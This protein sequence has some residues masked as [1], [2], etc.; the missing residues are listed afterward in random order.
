MKTA[1]FDCFSGISGNMILGA[2]LDAGL[3]FNVLKKQLSKLRIKNYKLQITKT[4]KNGIAASYF[5]VH[6]PHASEVHAPHAEHQHRSL[7]NI[8]SLINKS[9]LSS[10][11][12]EKS[13]GIFTRLAKAEAK[14]HGVSVNKIH[15]HEV[16]AV[17]AIVDIV[18]AVC[19]LEIM[20][21]EEIYCSPLPV[22]RG[23]INCA[24]GILPVPAPATAELIK[25]IPVYG[26]RICGEL[27]TPTGSAIIT[28]LAKSFGDCPEMKIRSI[29]YGAGKIDLDQP[30]ALRVLIGETSENMNK[31][32][33]YSVETNIDDMNPQIF[34]DVFESLFSNGALDVYMTSII[35]KKGR[36]GILLTALCK[37]KDINTLSEIIL[38]HTTSLG[39]RIT[40]HS[41]IVADRE[42]KTVKTKYGN[43]RFKIAKLSGKTVN[44][45]PEYEYCKKASK[46]YGVPIKTIMAEIVGAVH[47][48]SVKK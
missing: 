28:T 12:K 27:V 40:K 34:E 30:N 2:L 8:I 13:I 11:V 20:G 24:H 17:D 29:G 3:S 9:K 44:I 33:I 26:S 10:S 39:V 43:M 47:E 25:G 45:R 18:G 36:P 23:Y 35:M 4:K 42:I 48:P 14:I 31:E 5:E 41:R 32:T 21:I 22:S 15:F 6:A 7:T 19:A 16:G 38:R 46:K 1:Y 37:E